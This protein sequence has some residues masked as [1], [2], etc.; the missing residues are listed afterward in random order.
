MRQRFPQLVVNQP[1]ILAMFYEGLD[2]GGTPKLEINTKK[3]NQFK[4]LANTTYVFGISLLSLIQ[5]E[6]ET[7]MYSTRPMGAQAER[8]EVPLFTA[9]HELHLVASSVT[10]PGSDRPFRMKM[11]ISL[12]PGNDR[13]IRVNQDGNLKVARKHAF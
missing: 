13:R 8:P 5:L 6:S 2:L 10:K 11:Q 4:A 7:L 12:K 1:I 3:P 9:T